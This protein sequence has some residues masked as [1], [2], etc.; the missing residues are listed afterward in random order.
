MTESEIEALPTI[1]NAEFADR[2]VRLQRL[3]AEATLDVLLVNSSESDFANVRYLSDYWPVFECAGVIVPPSG[4]LTLLIGPESET[5]ATDRSRLPRIR[6][7]SEY[8]ESAD[9]S[10]PD[11]EVSTYASA[12]AEAGVEN[13]R[14]I[15]IGGSFATNYLMLEGL[16]SAFPGAEMIRA[17]SLMTRLRS[18]KSEAEISCIHAAF[19][20]SEHAIDRL[21]EVIRPGITELQL[22]G[23]AQ[24]AIYARGAEYEGMVQYVLSGP[25][26]RHAISRSTSRRMQ[27]GEVVQLN[28][29]ARVAGYSSGVG[30]PVSL[31]R[32]RT[33]DRDVIEFGLEA[34]YATASWIRTGASASEVATRFRR[35][36]SEH[37]RDANFLY[38]PAHGL[39]LIEVEPPWVEVG[40]ETVFEPGMTFQIDTFALTPSFGLRWENGVCVRENGLEFLSDKH[41]EVLEIV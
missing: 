35:H 3:V 18:V 36:Y 27:H 14:R 7:L 20:I 39:G 12:F 11:I 37:G 1:S 15:G 25:N 6:L 21:L 23:V 33:E 30:R 38:G 32:L 17:D 9:P 34:H 2:A 26:S 29:S 31:G 13:P 8:R 24:E 4:D 40:S 5:F 22:V 41:M 19:D 10:Y 28:I 16:K